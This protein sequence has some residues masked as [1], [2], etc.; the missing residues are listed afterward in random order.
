MHTQFL[1]RISGIS[2]NPV[3]GETNVSFSAK[4]DEI[5]SDTID[6]LAEYCEM[7]AIGFARVEC[8]KRPPISL[9][10]LVHGVTGNYATK[11][12]KVVLRFH[13]SEVTSE[14]ESFLVEICRMG[15]PC[16]VEV[17]N[18]QLRLPGLETH[19]VEKVVIEAGG[20]KVELS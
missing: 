14:T 18:Q 13:K 3:Q 16:D 1:G 2:V 5:D 19:R 11:V 6:R 20:K 12:V 15:W 10:C 17:S 7:S 4:M 9:P 8:G